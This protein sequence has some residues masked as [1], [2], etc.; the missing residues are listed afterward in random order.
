MKKLLRYILA[1]SLAFVTPAFAQ[2]PGQLVSGYDYTNTKTHQLNV[3]AQGR[4]QIVGSAVGGSVF[5]NNANGVAPTQP[6]VFVGG[7]DGTLV[8]SL[9]TDTGGRAVVNVNGSVNVTQAVGT[10]LQTAV[11][12][13]VTT[14]APTYTTG[15]ANL[16]SLT[17]GGLLRSTNPNMELAQG[18]TTAGSTG[19]LVQ[20]SIATTNPT[21]TNGTTGPFTCNGAGAIYANI[22]SPSVSVAVV[23]TTNDSV[24]NTAN[25][26]PINSKSY[27]YNGT[28]WDR[29]RGIQGSDQSGT[30]VT[31]TANTPNSNV[32]AAIL[33][34]VSTSVGSSLILKASAGNLYRI[35]VTTGATQGYLMVFNAVTAPADGAVTPQLCRV[36]AANSSL[37]VD[38]AEIPQRYATG[39]TA[40]FSSTGC[41]TKTASATAMIEGDV[42]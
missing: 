3:D 13:A 5:G 37:E 15:T 10:S 22:G 16:L 21:G 24:S 26:F 32:N 31:S 20:C 27:V 2:P 4:L 18:A 19:P 6:P 14:A 35:A 34:V 9:L 23:T 42:E 12:G 17:T 33:P 40:V 8:R 39:I 28:T 38:H 7:W 1:F 41:F 36:I 29:I 11:N 30:G 25:T